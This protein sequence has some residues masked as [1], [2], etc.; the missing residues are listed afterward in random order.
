[1]YL[2]DVLLKK[3]KKLSHRMCKDFNVDE[4]AL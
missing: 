4:S 2:Y 3:E 1:M